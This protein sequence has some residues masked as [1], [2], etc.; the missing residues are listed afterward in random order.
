[1]AGV[2]VMVDQWV[3]TDHVINSVKT[4]L[5]TFQNLGT[6]TLLMHVAIISS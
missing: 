6:V 3:A 5:K 2:Y 4:F 1:M